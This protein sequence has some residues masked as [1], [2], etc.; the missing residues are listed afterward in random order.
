MLALGW[1]VATLIAF[2]IASIV[3]VEW[4]QVTNI[5]NMRPSSDGSAFCARVV[6]E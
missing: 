2:G 6:S 3:L 5:A 4:G 1:V